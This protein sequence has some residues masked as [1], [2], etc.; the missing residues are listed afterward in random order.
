M[1][2]SRALLMVLAFAALP[3]WPASAQVGGMPPGMSPSAPA[4]PQCQQLLSYWDE[5]QKHGQALQTAARKKVPPEEVCTLFK[6][7][8]A[9]AANGLEDHSA[10][11]G[12]PPEVIKQVRASHAKATQTAQ[13][14][15][16]VGA[17]VIPQRIDAP[18][19]LC[20]EKTLQPGVPCVK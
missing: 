19:P 3:L 15:C 4:P 9:A 1:T 5:T 14:V 13:Q 12:V 18:V 7:F 17:R 11:C 20:S 8:L 16:E 2:L 6:A 10:T